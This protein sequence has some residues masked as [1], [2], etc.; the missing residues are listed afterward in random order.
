MF[1]SSMFCFGGLFSIGEVIAMFSQLAPQERAKRKL[2]NL[3]VSS[4][5]LPLF[6]LFLF[7]PPR[8][9][10]ILGYY[11]NT[12]GL[13]ENIHEAWPRCK[14]IRVSREKVCII[15]TY[16]KNLSSSLVLLSSTDVTCFFF[17]FSVNQQL[18]YVPL[19]YCDDA[20]VSPN[21]NCLSQPGTFRL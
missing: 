17:I 2:D 9:T 16:I 7:S 8:Q 11:Q 4:F 18:R 13:E 5:C 10:L 12:L 14:Y 21:F 1:F 6:C 20:E 15:T 3:E 19:V